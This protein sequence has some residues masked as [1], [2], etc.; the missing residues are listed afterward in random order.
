MSLPAVSLPKVSL[1]VPVY[2]VQPWLAAFLASAGQQTLVDFELI[3]VDD[4]STDDSLALL[5]AAARS[6]ERIRVLAKHS[7]AGVA[8]ARQGAMEAARGEWLAFVDPDDTMLPDRLERMIAVATQLDVDWLADDQSIYLDGDEEPLGRLL[9]DE[10]PGA[11]PV[12]L[13]HLLRRDQPGQI[14]YGTL[15][16]VIRRSFLEHHGLRYPSVVDSCSDFVFQVDCGVA[17]ARMAL[18]N[19]PL[20]GYR[21]REGSKVTGTG[22]RGTIEKLRRANEA[23]GAIVAAGGD[24]ALS[25]ALAARGRAI[26]DLE[27]YFQLVASW[28]EGAGLAGV[29]AFA[30]RPEAWLSAARR[31]VGAARRRLRGVDPAMGAL[32]RST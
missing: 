24:G 30:R 29:Q 11:G 12:T 2:D 3:A 21:L 18:L 25:E 27:A 23:A 1:I 16:P 14:G 6:D 7:N 19:E 28:R 31:L 15:K 8:I 9:T 4:A 17:G 22:W 13:A 26:D 32:G 10:A 5:Q 20:Y